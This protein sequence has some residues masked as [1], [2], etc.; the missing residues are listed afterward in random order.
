ME[1]DY[2]AMINMALL[3]II[4]AIG[5]CIIHSLPRKQNTI[6]TTNVAAS[7][8]DDFGTQMHG[9]TIHE[10]VNLPLDQQ[11][12]RVDGPVVQMISNNE[13]IMSQIN[14][15]Y[16]DEE[17]RNMF[18]ITSIGS[19]AFISVHGGTPEIKNIARQKLEQAYRVFGRTTQ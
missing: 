1:I 9:M 2:V 13:M 14:K 19:I 8:M 7:P 12:Q 4:I 10:F 18:N 16:S 11:I 17:V 15:N 5:C 3:I 6:Q